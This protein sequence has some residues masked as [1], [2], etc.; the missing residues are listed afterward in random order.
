MSRTFSRNQL[1]P[2]A[3]GEGDRALT[4]IFCDK[5]WTH[6]TWMESRAWR[7]STSFTNVDAHVTLDTTGVHVGRRLAAPATQSHSRTDDEPVGA[8]FDGFSRNHQISRYFLPH[9][10][11]NH[12]T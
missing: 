3:G 4:V 10:G 11:K 7:E 2:E 5:R 12:L 6:R 8:V 9:P 1:L